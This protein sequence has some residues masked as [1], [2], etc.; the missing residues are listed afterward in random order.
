MRYFDFNGLP[1]HGL[2]FPQHHGLAPELAVTE[3][4]RLRLRP[5]TFGGRYSASP[6]APCKPGVPLRPEPENVSQ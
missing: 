5:H 6:S 1:V 4:R 3:P 2:M